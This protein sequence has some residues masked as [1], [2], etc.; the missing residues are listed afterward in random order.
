MPQADEAALHKVQRM[1]DKCSLL[2]C[3]ESHTESVFTMNHVQRS[4][5]GHPAVR[6][7]NAHGIKESCVMST[8]A[9]E[10]TQLGFCR[11][12]K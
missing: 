12:R 11:H 8:I 10:P 4:M 6:D 9:S 2:K 5:L 3:I 7:A 1:G